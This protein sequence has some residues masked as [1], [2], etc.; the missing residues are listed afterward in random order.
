MEWNIL[1]AAASFASFSG[2]GASLIMAS[3]VIIV[4]QHKGND[5]PLHALALFIVTLAAMALDT[6]VFASATGDKICARATTQGLIASSTL[7]VAIAVIALGVSWLVS[8]LDDCPPYLRLLSSVVAALGSVGAFSIL[9][10]WSIYYYKGLVRLELR[11]GPI[12]PFS[13]ALIPIGVFLG[14]TA[15][16][17]GLGLRRKGRGRAIVFCTICYMS[18]VIAVMLAYVATFVVPGEWWASAPATFD[19]WM[20]TGVYAVTLV[21]PMIE[22]VAVVASLDWRP[23]RPPLTDD[24]LPMQRFSEE[25]LAEHMAT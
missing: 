12:W 7:A 11:P 17:I 20:L 10:L 18:H 9:V 4:I 6:F 21:F 16:V 25:Q 1:K 3:I 19:E 22:L 24:G 8:T 2:L 15:L 13:Y 23:W 14:L 5:K